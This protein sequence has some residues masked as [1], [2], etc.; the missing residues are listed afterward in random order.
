MPRMDGILGLG[1]RQDNVENQLSLAQNPSS[2][3]LIHFLRSEGLIKE[4]IASFSL[5][6]SSS[7]S[8]VQFGERN[9]SQVVED[10]LST[11]ELVS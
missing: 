4:A 3:S 7:R 6:Q 5:S 10:K 1:P 11:F 9:M 8:Y 2:I